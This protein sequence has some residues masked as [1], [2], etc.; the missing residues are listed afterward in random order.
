MRTKSKSWAALCSWAFERESAFVS[1]VLTGET[2][3]KSE[4]LCSLTFSSCSINLGSTLT[5]A[6]RNSAFK[7]E[8]FAIVL[9]FNVCFSHTLLPGFLFDF[10]AGHTRGKTVVFHSKCYLKHK[11]LLGCRLSSYNGVTTWCKIFQI[12]FFTF[13][14]HWVFQGKAVAD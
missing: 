11:V 1:L 13:K 4:P 10:V 3:K 2:P 5:W 12:L 6:A 8:S 7:R 14:C 9:L